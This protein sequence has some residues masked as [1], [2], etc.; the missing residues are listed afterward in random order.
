MIAQ[1]CLP[2]GGVCPYSSLLNQSV[3]IVTFWATPAVQYLLLLLTICPVLPVVAEVN[4]YSDMIVTRN[5]FGLKDP[6][7]PTPSPDLTPPAP[8]ITLV[9]IANV[10]GIKKVVLKPLAALGGPP[11]SLASGVSPLGQEVPIVLTEGATQDGIEVLS[12]DEASGTVRVNNNGQML[13]LSFEKDGLKVPN[14]PVAIASGQPGLLGQ[15]G[16]ARPPSLPGNVTSA[17]VNGFGTMGTIPSLAG[18]TGSSTTGSSGTA[19]PSGNL[20][21]T[22][23]GGGGGQQNVPQRPVRTEAPAM[24]AEQQALMIEVNRERYRIQGFNPPLPR[25]SLTPTP[26]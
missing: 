15:P 25:T 14:G 6:P 22:A 10:L 5:V 18:A 4:P 26:Q 24:T 23:V 20:G 7:P 2:P 16:I 12:I 9:G 13:T 11:K 8:K 3:L 21:S 17:G 19:F 1:T